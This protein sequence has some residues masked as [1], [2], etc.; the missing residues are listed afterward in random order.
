MNIPYSRWFRVIEKRRSRRRFDL[1][2]L[3]ATVLSQ[4]ACACTD[5]RPFRNARA[6]V[7]TESPDKVFKG[8]I[9]P[10]GKIKGAPAFIAFIGNMDSPNVWEQVGYTGEGIILEAE[11]LNLATCWVAGFFR[12]K[13][14]ASLT[15]I[16][17]GER[18]LAVTPIGY[19]A[20]SH[21]L[22]ERVM[23]GF[24][25]THR[26]RPLSGLVTGL[27]EPEWPQWAK[28]AL[29]AARLAPSAVNRQPWRFKV[30]P[31]SVTVS[32]N[33]I[34]REYGLSKRLCCGIAMLHIEVAALT[35]GM[36]GSWEFLE[37]PLVARFKVESGRN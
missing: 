10:Y 9:G 17:K 33:T 19:A 14:V 37:P 23:T 26:R 30:E 36:R 34:G 12:P 6:A 16:G 22:E 32:V 3:E 7:I 8:A 15:E 2:P 11:A 5:F 29:E 35:C 31:D 4:I 20:R 25:L 13:M 24:G 28:L 21:S 27:L 18:V 1:K